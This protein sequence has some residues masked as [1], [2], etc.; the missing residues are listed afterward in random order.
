MSH[1]SCQ[2]IENKYYYLSRLSNRLFLAS[3][4]QM[5]DFEELQM[6]S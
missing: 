6:V 2:V 3:K 5:V 4:N 1:V